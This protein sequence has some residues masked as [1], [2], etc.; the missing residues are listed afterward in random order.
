MILVVVLMAF[1]T[2]SSYV[3]QAYT[4]SI[5]AY[6]YVVSIYNK[7]Q[8]Y[9]IAQSAFELAKSILDRDDPSVD[10]LNDL[11]ALPFEFNKDNVKVKITIYDENRFINLNNTKDSGYRK[12]YENLFRNLS[13]NQSFLNRLYV[14]TG[15]Q[16]GSIPINYP[17]KKRPLDSLYELKL[18]G[19]SDE[20]LYGKMLGNQFYP[21]LLSISTV[22]TDGKINVN[23]APVPVLKALNPK[24]DDNLASKIVDY[25]KKNPFKSPNDLVLVQGFTFDM[26]Y[27]ISPYIDVKSSVFHIKIEVSVGDTN[28]QVDYIYNRNQKTVIYKEII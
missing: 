14:W 13:I 20:D 24:I 2:L 28:L 9:Y 15:A 18:L 23:T 10:T 11:W 5:S 27:S 1:L 7:D 4:D 3:L 25:R 21:G 26:L 19:F 16:E 6:K 8:A 12:I 17:I 22:F